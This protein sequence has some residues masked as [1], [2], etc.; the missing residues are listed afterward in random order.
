MKDQIESIVN[1]H[2]DN[3]FSELVEEYKLNYGDISPEDQFELDNCT[4]KITK[5]M[6]TYVNSNKEVVK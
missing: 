1:Y 3:I 4:D 2:I 5:I 6:V